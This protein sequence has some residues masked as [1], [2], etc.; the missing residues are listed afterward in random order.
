MKSTNINLA[1]NLKLIKENIFENSYSCDLYQNLNDG[2]M[3][4]I[5]K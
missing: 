4:F 1:S 3:L 2:K 5:I